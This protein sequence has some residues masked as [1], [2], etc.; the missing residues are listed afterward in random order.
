VLTINVNYSAGLLI[1]AL[2]VSACSKHS[3]PP[4]PT[5]PA[6]PFLS[7]TSFSPTNGPDSTTVT[8]TGTDTSLVAIVP[9]LA[10]TGNVVIK[11]NGSTT[12]GGVF[13]YDT[14]WRVTQLLGGLIGPQYLSID[15]NS[16]LYLTTLGGFGDIYK[17]TPQG[18]TG[19]LISPLPSPEGTTIDAAGNIYV[20][21]RLPPNG[22][23]VYMITQLGPYTAVRTDS[24][25]LS[26]LAIDAN[27]NLYGA[28]LMYSAIDKITPQGQVITFASNIRNP[29]GLVFDNNGNLYAT[30][31][32]N[33]YSATAGV[34]LKFSPTGNMTTVASGLMLSAQD[35]IAIDPDNNLYVTC[36]S[37]GLPTSAVVKI[38]PAGVIDT[39]STAFH[40]PLGIAVDRTGNVF[41]VDVNPMGDG[42]YGTLSKLMWH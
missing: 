14:T 41:V 7:I 38:T 9:G 11:T 3:T 16:N 42:I 8:I 2:S 15:V 17:I 28:D 40:I 12:T 37:P 25:E 5:H 1:A 4:S 23:T 29:S 33:P 21:S 6:P 36:Y 10:G 18:D 19:S 39:L 24:N 13:T 26:G 31:T 27:G 35:G 22:S 32:N 20:V 34:I 30:S